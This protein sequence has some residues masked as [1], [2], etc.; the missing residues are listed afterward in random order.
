MSICVERHCAVGRGLLC[1]GST[2]SDRGSVARR[3]FAPLVLAIATVFFVFASSTASVAQVADDECTVNGQNIFCG[4]CAAAQ[5]A[6]LIKRSVTLSGNIGN[7]KVFT[8]S[9]NATCEIVKLAPGE[10]LV[11]T[12][13]DNGSGG[14]Y[15][16]DFDGQIPN[17]TID[18]S[19]TTATIAPN[20]SAIQSFSSGVLVTQRTRA[21]LS[22]RKTQPTAQNFSVSTEVTCGCTSAPQPDQAR[23]TIKKT[24]VGGTGGTF[25]FDS[26]VDAL[27]KSNL[28]ISAD[29]TVDVS[30]TDLSTPFNDVT[31]TETTDAGY[32]TVTASCVNTADQTAFASSFSGTT[33]TVKPLAGDDVTCTF[34]NTAAGPPAKPKLILRKV[35]NDGSTGTFTFTSTVT[36]FNTSLTTA[37]GSDQS[38]PVEVDADM[39]QNVVEADPGTDYELI[40]AS[41]SGGVIA[42]QS[43]SPADR[44]LFVTPTSGTITCTFSNKRKNVTNQALLT[45]RKVVHN[46]GGGTAS[47]FDFTLFFSGPGDTVGSG[48]M[49]EL[50]VTAVPVPTGFYTFAESSSQGYNLTNLK[51]NGVNALGGFTITSE[52][53]TVTCVFE[54]TFDPTDERMEEET[55]R[56]IHRR[57]DNLLSHGPDRARMLR[58]L[59]E[60][61]PPQSLKDGPMKFAGGAGQPARSM[62]MLGGAQMGLGPRV[63]D[64]FMVDEEVARDVT[65]PTGKAMNNTFFDAIAGQASRL[66]IAQTSFK[67]GTSLSQ[68]REMAAQQEEAKQKAKFTASGLNFDGSQMANPYVVPRTGFD[69][70][71]EGHISRYKDDVGG[72]R[73][74]GDFRIL[75]LGADYVLAPGILIGA[76]VQIDDTS[77]DIK[78]NPMVSGET[79]SIDGTGWMVG[80]Y[81]GVR[82]SD[83]LF[84]DT[85]AAWGT[86]DNDIALK[87][88][89]NGARTGSFDTTRWLATATLTGNER[90]GAWRFSPQVSVAYGHEE[91]DTYKNSVNQTI[92]GGEASI[93]RVSGT[94]EVGYQLH[95]AYGTTIEPHVSITGIYN[96]DTDSLVINGVQVQSDESRAKV[97]GGVIV[98]TP[99]GW[100]MRAA[101][102]FDGIGSGDFKSYGGSLWVNIPL[103]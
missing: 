97:E 6:P 30:S 83:S 3:L 99:T 88:D 17:T 68:L 5:N 76:L 66:G 71:M 64:P 10:K 11:L 74:D 13:T 47:P 28:I 89:V 35:T 90:R 42:A 51:C 53:N 20:G 49:N 38:L 18:P 46:D 8:G 101:A 91:Y 81:I 72:V 43:F 37:G 59:Q 50:A 65:N 79:G 14:S 103:N 7:N 98:M 58:R 16:V 82:L 86:S 9:Q 56:F 67:F 94:L 33:L 84:F 25:S 32:P 95:T 21:Q 1:A 19:S 15:V 26:S 4:T 40:G 60:G 85:R 36:E 73:R 100:G 41:C 48:K 27:D 102:N 70:W 75:Y 39:E 45:L 22:I 34:V 55:K 92:K 62:S 29:S 77:E 52:V 31:V 12:A 57:V 2:R 69:I 93:G 80:P 23:L 87:D 96:F 24:T 44:K 78:N 61:E 63:D 54:N